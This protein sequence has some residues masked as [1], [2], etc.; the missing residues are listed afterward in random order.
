MSHHF[1]L[2]SHNFSEVEKKKIIECIRSGSVN[3]II[4]SVLEAREAYWREHQLTVFAAAALQ[5]IM[6][7]P[8]RSHNAKDVAQ[9]AWAYAE[10]MVEV[11]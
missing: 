3:R 6:A 8:N 10:A 4:D 2:S 9:V 1:K 11:Q 5:S 7:A